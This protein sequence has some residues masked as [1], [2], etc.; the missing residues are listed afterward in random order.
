MTNP[1]SYI[2][3]KLLSI[4]CILILSTS[5]C[6][7]T[8]PGRMMMTTTKEVLPE[9]IPE[10][11]K[12]YQPRYQGLVSSKLPKGDNHPRPGPSKRHH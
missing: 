10:N 1:K 4:F 3:W 12:H 2:S 5:P 8:R 9:I 11:M 7:A 6:T